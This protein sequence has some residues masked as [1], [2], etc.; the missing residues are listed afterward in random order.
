MYH[1]PMEFV[2]NAIETGHPQNLQSCL[3]DTFRHAVAVNAKTTEVQ[4]A[5][6]RTEMMKKWKNW[7]QSLNQKKE[8]SKRACHPI[9]R[10]SLNMRGLNSGKVFLETPTIPI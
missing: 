8:S 5:R 10:L 1:E 4:R 3:P 2:K 9:F 6:L 7:Q